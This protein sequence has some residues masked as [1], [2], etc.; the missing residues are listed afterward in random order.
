VADRPDRF[1]NGCPPMPAEL[2]RPLPRIMHHLTTCALK[3]WLISDALSQQNHGQ[4]VNTID[5]I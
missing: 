2:Q 4:Q 1:F 5:G 3:A